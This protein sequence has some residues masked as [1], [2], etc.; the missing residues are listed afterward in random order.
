MAQLALP[1]PRPLGCPA[2]G[3]QQAA[4]A[5]P[6]LLAALLAVGRKPIANSNPPC[7]RGWS[8]P[9]G[10]PPAA[11]RL[12]PGGGGRRFQLTG[13]PRRAG[14]LL[15]GNRRAIGLFHQAPGRRLAN[16]AEVVMPAGKRTEALSC[17]GPL[18]RPPGVMGP[19]PSARRIPAVPVGL[20]SAKPAHQHLI[21]T[22]PSGCRVASKQQDSFEPPLRCA[23]MAAM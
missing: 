15:A 19:H 21:R 16:Q 2:G 9:A 13:E 22:L 20:T 8:A 4:A 12:D 14:T 7:S 1:V 23:V 11:R 18:L 5:Q 6:G 10:P 3:Q 17:A